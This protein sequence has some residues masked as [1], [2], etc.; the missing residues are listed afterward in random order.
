MSIL[1]KNGQVIDPATQ[2]DEISDVLIENGVITRVEKG[3]RV[4][5]AQ[6][7]DAKGC[8][9]MPGIIDMHVHLR[10][11]G[12]T[13]KEDIESGSKAAAKG[14][15]VSAIIGVPRNWRICSIR[16]EPRAGNWCRKRM[17]ST[18][19]SGRNPLLRNNSRIKTACPQVRFMPERTGCSCFAQKFTAWAAR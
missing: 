19:S 10:D 15:T 18:S 1:I 11:P 5:D 14:P 16:W 13:Y 7:I 4:K 17:D 8:Y 9:V 12:Q 3:I 6:V 2:K